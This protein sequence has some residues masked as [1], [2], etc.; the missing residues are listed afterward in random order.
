[1]SARAGSEII[2][3]VAGEHVEDA[4]TLFCGHPDLTAEAD[5]DNKYR[6]KVAPTAPPGIYEVRVVGKQGLSNSRLFAVSRDLEEVL[7]VEPEDDPR[8]PQAVPLNV[9]IAGESDGNGVDVFKFPARKNQ[10]ITI[11]CQADRLDSQ[12]RGVLVLSSAEGKLLARSRPYYHRTDPLLDFVAPADGDYLVTIHDATYAGGHPYRLVISD[13]PHIENAFPPAVLPGRTA[14]LTLL[15]R[16]LPGGRRPQGR[17]LESLNLRLAVP[18]IDLARARFPM[19][20]LL[21]S[22]SLNAPGLQLRPQTL[23]KSLNALTLLASDVPVTLE[24]EPNDAAEKAQA[25]TLPAMV[26]GRFDRPGDSDWF[27]MEA[28]AN[29]PVAIELFAERLGAPGDPR[30]VILDKEG[31]E[32]ATI[33]DHGVD[34]GGTELFQSNRDSAG[35][36]TPPADG[37]YRLL[38]QETYGQGGE[39]FVYALR[40]GLPRPDFAPVAFLEEPNE[41]G[42]LVVRKGG[43]A[44]CEVCLNRRDG[45]TGA[46]TVEA[47]GLPPGIFCPPAIVDS[48]SEIGDVVFTA[49]PDAP[50]WAGMVRLRAWATIDEK[51]VEREVIPLTRRWL[52]VDP[53]TPRSTR[54]LGLSVRPGAPYALRL[55]R[56][57]ATVAAGSSAVVSVEVER[58]QAGFGDKIQVSGLNPPAGFEVSAAEISPGDAVVKVTIAVGADV[59]PARYTLVLRGDAQVP[60]PPGE[61][62]PR[63]RVADPSTPMT[64][65]VTAQTTETAPSSP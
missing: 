62:A 5:E 15:G 47:E 10:R 64:F 52:N 30:V 35:L 48:R 9:A 24:S 11:D 29:E 54:G 45:F 51:R 56:E 33:D 38:I 49:S 14:E 37:T 39:R 44:F 4:M 60:Y 20:D 25:L 50:E 42:R 43:S 7:E 53:Q 65:V 13:Y 16:N 36:F 28:K 34:K 41:P 31:N 12:L 32:V 1:L 18:D 22:P 23:G 26:C 8:L 57:P 6:L 61:D 40:V 2:L 58:L 59:P 46:V 55:P 3:E 27:A 21:P 63:V 17:S 19:L